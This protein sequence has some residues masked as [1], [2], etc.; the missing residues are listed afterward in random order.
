MKLNK[1]TDFVYQFSPAEDDELIKNT[2]IYEA[3]RK[4]E[5]RGESRGIEIGEERRQVEIAQNLINMNADLDFISK[6]TGLS[7]DKLE[8]IKENM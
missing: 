5:A 3:Q 7:I 2:R 1:D 6:A 8:S 4:G